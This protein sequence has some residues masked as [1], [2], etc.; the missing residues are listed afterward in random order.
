MVDEEMRRFLEGVEGVVEATA[1]ERYRLWE[2][3]TKLEN[4]PKWTPINPGLLERVGYLEIR[5]APRKFEKMP[6]CISLFK[7]Q[8]DELLL[9]FCHPTSRVVDFRMIR[10]WLERVL[11]ESARDENCPSGINHT[12]AA[13]FHIVVH[14]A[15]R[16]R[17]IADG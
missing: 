3:Y 17:E 12:D 13:N 9:L 5:T 15:R 6:V 8:F 14:S 11:P 7:V 10:S 1:E 4:P 2:Y 16:R